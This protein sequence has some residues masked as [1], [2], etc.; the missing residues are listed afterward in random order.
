MDQ[1][2][3][4]RKEAGMESGPVTYLFLA[5]TA[6]PVSRTSHSPA[7]AREALNGACVSL[8]VKVEVAG[9]SQIKSL[10]SWRAQDQI[11]EGSGLLGN[12]P[13]LGPRRVRLGQRQKTDKSGLY[14]ADSAGPRG[15]AAQNLRGL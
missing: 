11:A 8:W 5:S 14:L 12:L 2:V 10:K 9:I 3:Q 1:K 13:C 4:S 6:S 7:D 15:G